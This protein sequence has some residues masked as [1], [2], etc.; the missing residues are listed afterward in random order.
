MSTLRGQSNRCLAQARA[1]LG[2]YAQQEQ[3]LSRDAI[4]HAAHL[5]LR[6]CYRSLLLE[7]MD[8]QH[9]P[10]KPLTASEAAETLL[11]VGVVSP[12]LEM[13]RQHESGESAVAVLLGDW[14]DQR[15]MTGRQSDPVLINV[16]QVD[17]SKVVFDQAW[18]QNACDELQALLTSVRD[19]GQQW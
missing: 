9:R 11:A 10:E 2:L 17:E 12:E 4:L 6:Q 13:L 8:D 3:P 5:L 18:Y 15:Q 1:Q 16:A 14:H 7:I 19:M